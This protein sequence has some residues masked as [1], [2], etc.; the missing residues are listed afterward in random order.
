MKIITGS[1]LILLLLTQTFSTW[2][3]V[4]AFRLNREYI[5]KNLCENRYR[6]QLNCKGNCVLMKKMKKEAEQEK[7]APAAIKIEINSSF[8]FS[9]SFESADPPVFNSDISY[10]TIVR[11]GRPVDRALAIFHPP[12]A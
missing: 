4:M 9:G 11:S 2:F 1:I 3:V 7:N 8:L 12:S 5:A 6:P 10:F